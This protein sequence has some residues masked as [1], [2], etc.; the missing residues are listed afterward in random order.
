MKKVTKK[1]NKRKEILCCDL[2]P[3]DQ[4]YYEIHSLIH[5]KPSDSNDTNVNK[6][7]KIESNVQ[8]NI[9]NISQSHIE[10]NSK[11]HKMFS[12]YANSNEF[13]NAR[14][15][16]IHSSELTRMVSNFCTTS[17]YI[18]VEIFVKIL[19]SMLSKEDYFTL[20][21]WFGGSILDTL[22][23]SIMNGSFDTVFSNIDYTIILIFHKCLGYE[24]PIINTS[25]IYDILYKVIHKSGIIQQFMSFDISVLL[26]FL[27]IEGISLLF[28]LTKIEIINVLITTIL[29]K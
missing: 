11:I 3:S 29:C 23:K 1:S 18:G 16:Q 4:I 27:K 22:T 15:K 20:N 2:D 26:R 19:E 7:V 8:L 24:T 17:L 9:Q 21:Q 5:T 10:V 25:S 6:K 13:N 12:L 28:N 14:I